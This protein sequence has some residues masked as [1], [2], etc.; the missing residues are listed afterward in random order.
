MKLPN[1]PG[2]WDAPFILWTDYSY[3]QLH[4]RSARGQ[5]DCSTYSLCMLHE[6][7]YLSEGVWNR[8]PRELQQ[9]P[10]QRW[11]HHQLQCLVLLTA[12][13]TKGEI[14]A[15]REIWESC[16]PIP[17]HFSGQNT[18]RRQWVTS[19][20]RAFFPK[21]KTEHI[22]LTGL[23][24]PSLEEGHRKFISISNH[25]QIHEHWTSQRTSYCIL[26]PLGHT[27]THSLLS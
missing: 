4:P 17:R 13:L 10:Q 2:V 26:R 14:M 24:F 16:L 3:F 1:F 5:N 15:K 11:C 23:P 7:I 12:L 27:F 19:R 18:A 25:N 22:H 8:H 9:W 6:F 21:F 20:S